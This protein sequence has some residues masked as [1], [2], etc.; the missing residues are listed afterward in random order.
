MAYTVPQADYT[1]PPNA[2]EVENQIRSA[3]WWPQDAAQEAASRYIARLA[4]DGTIQRIKRLV[5]WNPFISDGTVAERY[6]QRIDEQ[7]RIALGEGLLSL[8]SVTIL[9]R[10]YTLNENIF[11]E[12]QNA[13]FGTDPKPYTHLQL[14]PANYGYSEN[15]TF[16]HARELKPRSIVVRGTWGQFDKWPADLYHAAVDRAA[17]VTLSA[18]N[19]EQEL[20]SL[21]QDSF[22]EQ[23][24]LVG[25]IDQKRALDFWGQVFEGVVKTYAKPTPSA[26]SVSTSPNDARLRRNNFLPLA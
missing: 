26:Q 25:P 20:A 9:G 22:S 1:T 10:A 21:S 4:I 18:V 8:E 13:R 14:W 23:Y 2:N 5:R 12:P 15:L 16:R 11:C 24:D 17:G 6:L 19:Q 7:G 3:N